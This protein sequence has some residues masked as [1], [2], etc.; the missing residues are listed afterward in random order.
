VTPNP[1]AKAFAD[2][3]EIYHQIAAQPQESETMTNVESLAHEHATREAENLALPRGLTDEEHQPFNDREN[4][5]LLALVKEP[6]I[7]ARDLALKLKALA[8]YID[9]AS[10]VVYSG[11]V[12]AEIER[13]ASDEGTEH[14]RPDVARVGTGTAPELV[15]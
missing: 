11:P 9:L 13:L 4:A 10:G 2:F 14:R 15:T 7:T 5:A 6:S 8:P 12:S 3:A 1:W